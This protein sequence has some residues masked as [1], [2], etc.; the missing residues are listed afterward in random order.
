R[1]PAWWAATGA[2][3]AVLTLTRAVYVFAVVLVL[4]AA[5]VRAPRARGAAACLVGAAVLLGPWL[6]WNAAATGKATVA[7]FGEGWN[8][9]LAAH[10]EGLGHTA[11]EVGRSPAFRRDFFSV[12]RFA[13]SP[14]RLRDDRD[15]HPRYLARADAEQRRLAW[16]LYRH[17]LAHE[18]DDVAGEIAY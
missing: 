17:R 7:S 9:L 16:R 18:P 11:V 4:V 3:A 1:S 8:L 13:P 2:S 5:F 14:T 15:A 10:G 12:H 6:A